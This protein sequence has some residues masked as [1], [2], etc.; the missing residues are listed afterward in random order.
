MGWLGWVGEGRGGKGNARSARLNTKSGNLRGLEVITS[1]FKNLKGNNGFNP[2]MPIAE[3]AK[4]IFKK[5]RKNIFAVDRK[6]KEA[7]RQSRVFLCIFASGRFVRLPPG[8]GLPWVSRYPGFLKNRQKSA[9]YCF[10]R[11]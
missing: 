7:M 9:F 11:F 8:A 10:L 6:S 1:G 4:S 3:M 5:K 2:V